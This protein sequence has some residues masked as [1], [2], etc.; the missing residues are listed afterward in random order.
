[1]RVQVV[2]QGG[3]KRLSIA[4]AIKAHVR[5]N[6]FDSA[7]I[8]AA[9][10]TV[11]GIKALTT[12]L[13]TPPT[14]SR[15]IVGLDDA[16]SQPDAIKLLI[17]LPGAEVRV[18]KLSPKRRFHPKVY[19][20][21]DAGKANEAVLVIG[22]GNLT[23]RGLHENAEAAVLLTSEGPADAAVG[24]ELFSELWALGYTPTEAD[25]AAYAKRYEAAK[26]QRKAV[27]ESNDSPPEPAIGAGVS[28]AI[29]SKKTPEAVLAFAVTQIAAAQ[30]D[31]ICSLDL[32]R[33]LIP[34]MVPL[35]PADW[36]PFKGQKNPAW[37][38][39]L[40][41]IQ[42]NSN[43]PGPGSTNFIVRGYLKHVGEAYEVTEKGRML[44]DG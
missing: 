12:I 5:A 11:Q 21:W 15:W 31:G 13:G 14:Q 42:S 27:E 41:N 17:K 30:P 29:P 4:A 32:A 34:Q 26:R 9:Y 2:A 36:V 6:P 37:V 35:T 16:I 18:A 25:L 10:V 24:A 7:E 43:N 19:R 3:A 8:A 39:I 40:R 44:V 20:F 22:S 33:D 1:M 28:S 23:E 38:Q